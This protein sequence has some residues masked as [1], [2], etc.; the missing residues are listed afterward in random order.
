M[1]LGPHLILGFEGTQPDDDFLRLLSEEEIAGVILFKRNIVNPTQLAELI[2]TL[3]QARGGPL[4]VSVDHEGGRVFRLEEPF[5]KIPPAR[6]FGQYYERTQDTELITE[7]AR[8]IAVELKAVGFNLNY[9]PVLDVDSCAENPIIGDRAFHGD[10]EIVAAVAIAMMRGFAAGGVISC[11]KHFPGHGD[12]RE[13]SHL[14]LPCVGTDVATMRAREL[15]PFQRAIA[16]GIPTL[17]TAHVLY[18]AWDPTWCG[19]LSSQLNR[20]LL[21]EEL[22]FE[23]VLFSDDLFM[24][25]IAPEAAAVP[26]AACAALKAGCDIILLCH[27][28]ARQRET[29]EV[30]QQEV[31]ADAELRQA[32]E[33]AV[34]RV[35]KLMVQLETFASQ[36]EVSGA[37][38]GDLANKLAQLGS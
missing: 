3:K 7:I 27:D 35:A 36:V 21:R 10:P 18:S 2:Q 38:V 29:I 20:D 19:T 26:M 11:G 33:S 17:M 34:P 4:I 25:G 23:G 6:L 12:T 32:L 16:A 28:E 37:A 1:K 5:T 14:T 15:V 31:A 30:L 24:K 22:G 13:D 8:L 9:A